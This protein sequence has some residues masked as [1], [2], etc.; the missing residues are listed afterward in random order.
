MERTGET[1]GFKIL[2]NILRLTEL[3][4]IKISLK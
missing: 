2:R 1:V 4:K 3:Y